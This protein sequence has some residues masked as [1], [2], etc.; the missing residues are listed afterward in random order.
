M[1]VLSTIPAQV[2]AAISAI[3]LS[4]A[5][6]CAPAIAA[7]A[8]SAAEQI[9]QADS[10]SI[11]FSWKLKGEYAPFYVALDQ[12]YF[13][14]EGLKV[15]MGEGSG[16][17][18]TLAAVDQGQE[19]ATF[20][21]GVFGQQAISNGLPVKIIALYHP[22]TP[23]AI[24]S[25][26]TKPIR[27]PKDLEGKR[28]VTSVGD[29]VS[30]FLDVFCGINNVDCSKVEKIQ[31][32]IAGRLSAFLSGSVDAM[33]TYTNIDLPTLEEKGETAGL[34]VMDLAKFGLEVPGGSLIVSNKTVAQE[35]EKLKKLLRALNK[36]VAFCKKDA[37]AGAQI[38]KK[39]WQTTL[40]DHVVAEQVR[41]TM[42]A[43]PEQPGKP[44]GWVDE[45][46]F[47]TSLKHLKQVGK[48]KEILPL[49]KYYTNDLLPK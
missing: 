4:I 1:A 24:T 3:A 39:Y 40:S 10:A 43:V 17:Q 41:L 21:P 15:T 25:H 8:T 20:A 26:K 11:R 33:G 37:K 48:I 46:S 47:A 9:A 22:A 27:T 34:V 23:M 2:A 38:L 12:G 7:D 6:V 19:T 13:A 30:D 16:A 18:A 42:E 32:N 28:M 35:P 14:A 45:K 29:T 44:L 36:G 5:G 31:V 49:D